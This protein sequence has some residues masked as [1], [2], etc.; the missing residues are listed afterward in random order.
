MV[1]PIELSRNQQITDSSSISNNVRRPQAHVDSNPKW[2]SFFNPMIYS[3]AIFRFL[4]IPL[5][6]RV[7]IQMVEWLWA[8]RSRAHTNPFDETSVANPNRVNETHSPVECFALDA[9]SVV[10]QRSVNYR[11]CSA[12]VIGLQSKVNNGIVAQIGHN[13]DQQL[14]HIPNNEPITAITVRFIVLTQNE[15]KN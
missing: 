15:R 6:L 12:I 5:I 1:A 4:S 7:V 10:D 11:S 14:N 8:P 9:V 2:T 13:C 3:Q